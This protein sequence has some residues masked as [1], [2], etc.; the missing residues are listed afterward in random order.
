MGRPRADTLVPLTV[1]NASTASEHLHS[2]CQPRST[3]TSIPDTWVPGII[4]SC[5]VYSIS[6]PPPGRSGSRDARVRTL[7]SESRDTLGERTTSLR[8][9]RCRRVLWIRAAAEQWLVAA[10]G[11]EREHGLAVPVELVRADAG[12]R[13]QRRRVRRTLLGD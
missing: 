6:A 7:G 13:H 1:G 4:T 11:H 10:L 3:D 12:D 2:R 5:M 9:V 8:E